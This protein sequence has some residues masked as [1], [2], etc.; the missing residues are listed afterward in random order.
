MESTRK[1]TGTVYVVKD[2]RVLIHM[3]KK[4][5]T[6]FPV[7]R[8]SIDQELP[9][10]TAIR[11]AKE[12][13]GLDVELINT[14]RVGDVDLGYVKRLPSPF[15]IYEERNSKEYF[16]DYIYVG[17]AKNDLISPNQGESTELRWF[18]M[19]DICSTELKPHVKSTSIQILEYISTM[20][21]E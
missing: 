17:R 10:E 16:V 3:H 21:G 9:F 6:G 15:C 1:I 20:D 14:D 5:K 4:Y 11:E 8:H 7:G 12:E 18:S 19:T 2:N 13:S